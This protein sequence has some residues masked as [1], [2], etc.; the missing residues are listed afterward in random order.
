MGRAMVEQGHTGDDASAK[1]LKPHSDN[2]RAVR[3]LEM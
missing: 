2:D 3:D 1:T